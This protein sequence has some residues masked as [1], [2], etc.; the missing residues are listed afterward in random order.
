MSDSIEEIWKKGFLNNEALI[1]PKI[2]DLYNQKSQNIVDK[3]EVM[4]KWNL[5]GLAIFS[6]IVLISLILFGIPF[7]GVFVAGMLM[8][9]VIIGRKEQATL[10]RIDKNVNSYQYIK[11]FEQWLN[12]MM[13]R[14]RKLYSVFYPALFLGPVIQLR[15]SDIGQKAIHGFVASFPD[16]IMILGTPLIAL[17]TVSIIASLLYYFSGPLYRLDYNSLYG[18]LHAKL[19]DLIAD[20]EELQCE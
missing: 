5:I 18:R 4:F 9:L 8:S 6:V 14:Y 13:D 11:S 2:N 1:A 17:V 7:L 3:F 16:T 10:K 12:A 20:M 15:F 19:D